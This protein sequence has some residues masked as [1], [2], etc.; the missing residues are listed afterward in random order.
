[1]QIKVLL[2]GSPQTAMERYRHFQKPANSIAY[3]PIG[4][5]RLLFRSVQRDRRSAEKTEERNG[6]YL[7]Q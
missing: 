1:M 7:L 4:V 6:R 2:E 5:Q 3:G